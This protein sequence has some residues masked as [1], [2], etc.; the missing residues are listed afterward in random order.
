M[1][2]PGKSA[3]LGTFIVILLVIIVIVLVAYFAWWLPV[4][5]GTG[6]IQDPAKESTLFVSAAKK[7]PFPLFMPYPSRKQSALPL[8]KTVPQQV[9]Y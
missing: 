1:S 8:Q 7:K 9:L 6:V 4:H 2:E 3:I 5:R